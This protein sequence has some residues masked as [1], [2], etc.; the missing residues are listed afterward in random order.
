MLSKQKGAIKK[1]YPVTFRGT[2]YPDAETAYQTL[3]QG[4]VDEPL[5]GQI[6]AAKL[7]QYPHLLNA[8]KQNGGVRWLEQCQHR[9]H[10][11]TPA[12][13]AWEGIGRNSIMVRCLI[14]GYESAL[15]LQAQLSQQQS[16]TKTNLE[17]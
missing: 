9:T 17:R 1:D 13:Q 5:M 8:I 15:Q 3:A 7:M 10:A 12:F 4:K 14:G 6:I 16:K 2:V 11:K